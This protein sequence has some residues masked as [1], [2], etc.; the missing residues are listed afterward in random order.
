MSV[1]TNQYLMYA[2]SIPFPKERGWYDKYE[3]FCDDSAFNKKIVHHDGIFCLFDGMSG[4]YCLIGR[5]LEKGSNDDPCIASHG[6]PM[7]I[8]ISLSEIEK[9]F[10]HNSVKRNFN[11]EGDFKFYLITHYS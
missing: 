2:I 11:I 4:K 10:I 6:V 3:S 5:V 7:E 1:Q 9:E 8:P